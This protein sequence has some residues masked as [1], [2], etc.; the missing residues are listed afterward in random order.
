MSYH[1]VSVSLQ[2]LFTN[3]EHAR[4]NPY[5]A[6][7]NIFQMGMDKTSTKALRSVFLCVNS[8]DIWITIVILS[9]LY[10]HVKNPLSGNI[11]TRLR[12]AKNCYSNVG[13]VYA[14]GLY[15]C[16]PVQ[17]KT[18]RLTG[19]LSCSLLQLKR[20]PRRICQFLAVSTTSVTP[21]TVIFAGLSKARYVDEKRNPCQIYLTGFAKRYLQNLTCHW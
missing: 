19:V 7:Q 17:I 14:K 18:L 13:A 16:K 3:C 15:I 9:K 5:N 4:K 2:F 6:N 21:A 12:C 11:S 8:A 20:A 10:I 1:F